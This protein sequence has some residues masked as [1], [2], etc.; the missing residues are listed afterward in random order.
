[1]FEAWETFYLL[2]GTSAAALI[3]MMFVVITLTAEVRTQQ[4]ERGTV[5]YHNPIIFHLGVILAVSGLVL[6]P[7]HLVTTV[8]VLLVAMG[9]IGAGY[10]ALTLRRLFEPFEFYTATVWDK[11]FYGIAPGILY[12]LL[13]AGGTAIW[14]GPDLAGETIGAATLL[15]L[16]IAVRNAWDVATFAVRLSREQASREK[17]QK[18]KTAPGG[19]AS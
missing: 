19:A 17:E 8:A 16:L 18:A 11:L 6:V 12:L 13:T 1:M 9:L 10:C 3:G 4:I 5:I 15:L 2:I 7:D 14:W